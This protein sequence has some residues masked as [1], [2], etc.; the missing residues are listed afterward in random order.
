MLNRNAAIHN[1][2]IHPTSRCVL[3]ETSFTPLFFF[4]NQDETIERET[5]WSQ[6]VDTRCYPAC[7]LKAP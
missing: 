2:C 7:S 3:R 1:V 4:T 6:I 5:K